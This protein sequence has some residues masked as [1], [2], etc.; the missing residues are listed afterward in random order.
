[1]DRSRF[2]TTLRVSLP[3]LKGIPGI[4]SPPGWGLPR[5]GARGRSRLLSTPDAWWL[6]RYPDG[7][8]PEWAV[9]ITLLRMGLRHRQDFFFRTQIAGIAVDFFFPDYNVALLIRRRGGTQ[10]DAPRNDTLT[11]AQLAALGIRAVYL[12][13]EEIQADVRRVIQEALSI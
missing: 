5:Y 1:M 6:R 9:F 7:S 10:G 11:A 12:D 2:R 4:K 13:E 3:K 8:P